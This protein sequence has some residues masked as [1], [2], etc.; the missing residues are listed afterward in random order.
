[1][2]Y[3]L[4]FEVLPRPAWVAD[5]ESRKILLVND[6]AIRLYG[7]SREEFAAMTLDDLRP[8]EDRSSFLKVYEAPKTSPSY[9][10]TS[11]HWKKDGTV[12]EVAFEVTPFE[13]DGRT[14]SLATITDITGIADVERKFRLLA[15]NSSEAIALTSA[16][17]I[18]EYVSP[19]AERILG[20]P[21]S[22][23]IGRS[24]VPRVHPEDAPH[25][26]PPQPGARTTMVVRALHRD[27]TWRWLEVTTTNLLHDP[28]VRAYVSNYRD[29]TARVMAEQAQLELQRRLE[30]LLS[31]TSAI[32][33]SVRPDGEAM[34]IS[35]SV[36]RVLG[37]RPEQFIAEAIWLPNIHPD[38]LA[39]VVEGKRE[40][41]VTGR[42]EF[43]YRFRHANGSYRWMRDVAT[44]KRDEHGQ[45][46]EV[47]GY[48]IDITDEVESEESLRRSEANFRTLMER[49]PTASLVQRDGKYVYVN[50]AWAAM[51]GYN[52]AADVIGRPVLEDVHPDDRPRV[53]ERMQR[54]LASGE[55]P[56]SE[57]RLLR[58][59][60][61]V[62][63]LEMQGMVVDFDGKPATLAIG[64]DVTERR[65]L[66]ERM[67]LADRML[68]VGTL[69]AGVAHEINNPL[70]YTAA[71]LEVLTSEVASLLANV[72][73][74]LPPRDVLGLISDAREGV[75]R[76]SAIVR[77][78]RALARPDD[79]S[80]GAVD[81]TAVLAS[82][83]KMAH[84][85]IRH[86][87]RVIEHR[88]P[89]LPP[90]F[91]HAS[92]LGQV[93]LN[94]LINAAQ[95]IP[96]GRA[97]RNEI[98]V[99]AL[100]SQDRRHVHVE[101]ED[102]GIGIPASLMRRIFDPF[103]TTKAPGVGMGLGLAISHQIVKTMDG[104]IT[105]E[106]SPGVG[107]TFR[108]TLP[109]ATCAA[110]ADRRQT[111][112]GGTGGAR[113]LFIDDEAALGRALCALLGDHEIVPVTTARDALS[114][115]SG[116]ERFDVILCDLMMPEVSGIDLWDQIAPTYRDR[117]VFMTGGAFTQ[118]ARDF[119]ARCERP[120]LDKPF[121]ERQLRDAIDRIRSTRDTRSDPTPA[122]A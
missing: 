12:I 17:E 8:P 81:V 40:L 21:A 23:V 71:N 20:Y 62:V 24:P 99:R 95:A 112:R 90:V 35:A 52:S 38:D 72:P 29:I 93:F 51:L 37:Y 14:A 76:V 9:A 42:K 54:A 78:L 91:A 63:V 119:L 88:A 74:R 89:E 109:T 48:W 77:D 31:A 122:P 68:T 46:V 98:R 100:P 57:V 116:G 94:L 114:K 32:T 4:L 117:V 26:G 64:T 44:L 69:A 104:E 3:R 5:R 82:S 49:S 22:E 110:T 11:R 43:R 25:W 15:E 65:D 27:G 39:Q 30:Y 108:I 16:N 7:W 13:L 80:R 120:H 55:T 113:I 18:V 47:V 106:S 103:F 101:I 60:G 92:R 28:A 66:F 10:R 102:T 83:I 73:T 2:D 85:E 121:S 107:T 61:S 50:P 75:A 59:D 34:F 84:N 6:A 96:E 33:Y 45:P 79:D 67:A 105:V 87:A 111:A 19:A 70:A 97:D 118:Q 58:R 115:L 53:R 41:R 86:R 1:M 56:P 36:E